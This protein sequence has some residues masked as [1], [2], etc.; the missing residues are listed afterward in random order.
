MLNV[1]DI[2]GY[3][4]FIVTKDAINKLEALYDDTVEAASEE[5]NG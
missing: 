3:T 2:L 1:V 4:S 5:V